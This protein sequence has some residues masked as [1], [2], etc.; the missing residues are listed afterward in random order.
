MLQLQTFRLQ[1]QQGLYKLVGKTL[2]VINVF[3]VNFVRD[4]CSVSDLVDIVGNIIGDA[5]NLFQRIFVDMDDVTLEDHRTDKSAECIHAAV[6]KLLLDSVHFRLTH[7]YLQVQITLILV[8]H[9]LFLSS[10]CFY[11]FG[12]VGAAPSAKPCEVCEVA[13]CAHTLPSLL[14]VICPCGAIS[15]FRAFQ[16][17]FFLVCQELELCDFFCFS[18]IVAPSLPHIHYTKDFKISQWLSEKFFRAVRNGFV[19]ITGDILWRNNVISY[20]EIAKFPGLLLTSYEQKFVRISACID[21]ELRAI[22]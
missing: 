12:V 16:L 22:I 17:G 4:I 5:V 6:R 18:I 13:F 20:F 3:L 1:K 15:H 19:K 8:F 11:K 10:L 7:S 2:D 21:M 9:I 14:G